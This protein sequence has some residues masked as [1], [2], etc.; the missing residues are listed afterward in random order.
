[1]LTDRQ[2]GIRRI[3]YAKVYRLPLC[4]LKYQKSSEKSNYS[5]SFSK[6]SHSKEKLYSFLSTKL[7]V[8]RNINARMTQQNHETYFFLSAERQFLF[9]CSFK[10]KN[11]TAK[12]T[13]CYEQRNFYDIINCYAIVLYLPCAAIRFAVSK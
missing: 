6:L 9:T 5:F 10:T 1:M 11:K 12:R 8:R 2:T 3:S 4:G 13:R 7:C